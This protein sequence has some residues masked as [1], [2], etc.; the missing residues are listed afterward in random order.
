MTC[1][2]CEANAWDVNGSC[3]KQL[4]V[5]KGVTTD[6]GMESA[7]V[8]CGDDCRDCVV[9]QT[10]PT[11]KESDR[12]FRATAEGMFAACNTCNNNKLLFDHHCIA[13]FECPAANTQFNKFKHSGTCEAPFACESGR[14]VQGENEGRR[15]KCMTGKCMNCHWGTDGHSC[16]TC[17]KSTYLLNGSCLGEADCLNQGRYVPIR[18]D[19]PRGGVCV[20]L[21]VP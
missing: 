5:F 8:S 20:K 1:I 16:V 21:L 3:L 11:A 13:N 12:T 9:R 18:G 4:T 6:E 19:G 14:K 7:E 15:C 2:Q 10:M 17:K